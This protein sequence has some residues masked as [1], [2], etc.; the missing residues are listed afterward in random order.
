MVWTMLLVL[1]M[2]V[3]VVLIGILMPESSEPLEV[4]ED[5]DFLDDGETEDLGS[6]PDPPGCSSSSK[7]SG[8]TCSS[9][10]PS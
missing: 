3:M 10:T 9:T 1:L 5:A 7:L 8:R 2:L 4:C 6:T